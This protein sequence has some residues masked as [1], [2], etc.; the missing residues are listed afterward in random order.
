M[1]NNTISI[2]IPYADFD[3]YVLINDSSEYLSVLH[4]MTIIPALIYVL[5]RLASRLNNTNE[6]LDD[7]ECYSWYRVLQ[8]RINLLCDCD[9]TEALKNYSSLALA[10]KLISNP[11]SKALE[12]L[13][14]INKAQEET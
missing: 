14:Y 4:S 10:Q 11:F 7:L 5:E 13:S 9:I 8:K 1:E 12:A 2:K 3:R 6:S